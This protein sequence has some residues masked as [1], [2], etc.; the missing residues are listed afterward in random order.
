MSRED[1]D[2][3]TLSETN[4]SV[5]IWHRVMLG[6][7]YSVPFFVATHH[8]FSPQLNNTAKAGIGICLIGLVALAIFTLRPTREKR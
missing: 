8:L 2:I 6:M 7:V 5:E 1:A 3:Q 4:H